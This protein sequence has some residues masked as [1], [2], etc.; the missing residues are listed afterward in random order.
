MFNA[1]YLTTPE[2]IQEELAEMQAFLEMEFSNENP[3]TCI[4]RMEK[5]SQYMSRSGKLKSDAEYH[6][7]QVYNSSIMKT[8]KEVAETYMSASTINAYIKSAC[9]DYNYI[10]TWA[11]RT[12]RSCVH[13]IDKLRTVIS[14]Q[15]SERQYQ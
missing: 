10:L 2:Q 13:Q 14:Y 12:N 8:L 11:D 15:K 1:S 3:V 5:L 4:D 6:Y 7:F 9:R